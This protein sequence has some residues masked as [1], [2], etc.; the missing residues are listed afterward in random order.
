M[1]EVE[2]NHTVRTSDPT[3]TDPALQGI[4][5]NPKVLEILRLCVVR[6]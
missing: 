1:D 2:T 6:K 3:T 4:S 5:S